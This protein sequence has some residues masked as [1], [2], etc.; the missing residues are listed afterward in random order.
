VFGFL[1]G[2]LLMVIFAAFGYFVGYQGWRTG[3]WPGGERQTVKVGEHE[4]NI[5]DLGVF[6][7]LLSIAGLM[8]SLWWWV[9][10]GPP[11]KPVGE[12]AVVTLAPTPNVGP[13]VSN[14]QQALAPWEATSNGVVLRVATVDYDEK[15]LAQVRYRITNTSAAVVEGVGDYVYVVDNFGRGRSV[16]F[17]ESTAPDELTLNPGQE[18]FHRA[19]IS[20]PWARNTQYFDVRLN[21]SYADSP[22]FFTVASP[23]IPIPIRER[24]G[25]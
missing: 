5:T 2:L 18:V 17:S 25:E 15:H 16:D 13:A 6:V 1:G 20:L 7:M 4:L 19:E 23:G 12:P 21:L 8:F 22:Q 10:P 9:A 11:E 14:P 3:K 24:V